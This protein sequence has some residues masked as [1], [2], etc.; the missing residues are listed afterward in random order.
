MAAGHHHAQDKKGR[1]AQV[2]GFGCRVPMCIL[3][4]ERGFVFGRLGACTDSCGSK[5]APVVL[6]LPIPVAVRPRQSSRRLYC[7]HKVEAVRMCCVCVRAWA[8]SC[9]LQL[10]DEVVLLEAALRTRDSHLA[11]V[12]E[13]AAGLRSDLLESRQQ[14]REVLDFVEGGWLQATVAL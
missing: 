1:E 10:K 5:P 4:T 11:A 3:A 9:L 14:V 6:R 7:M 8:P 2:N 13:T 12:K